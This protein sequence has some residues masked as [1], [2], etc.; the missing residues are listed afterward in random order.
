MGRAQGSG[1][2]DPYPPCSCPGPGVLDIFVHLGAQRLGPSPE[3][4][5]EVGDWLNATQGFLQ[6]VSSRSSPLLGPPHRT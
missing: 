6:A 5:A 1:Q 3:P 2:R 4:S